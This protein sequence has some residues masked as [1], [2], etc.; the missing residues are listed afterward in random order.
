[1]FLRGAFFLYICI[2]EKTVS[3]SFESPVYDGQMFVQIW[4]SHPC[5]QNGKR[6]MATITKS[7]MLSGLVYREMWPN[8][9]NIF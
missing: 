6:I 3:P 7:A 5:A 9:V 2:K 4:P 1:M 8:L